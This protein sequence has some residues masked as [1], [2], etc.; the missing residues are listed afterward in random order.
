MTGDHG[1]DDPSAPGGWT[2]LVL[3]TWRELP[4]AIRSVADQLISMT[5]RSAPATDE[6][7]ARLDAIESQLDEHLGH[8]EILGRRELDAIRATTAA[9]ERRVAALEAHLR[10]DAAPDDDASRVPR[11]P[12]ASPD[13]F[14]Q[15]LARAG[16]VAVQRGLTTGTVAATVAGDR[17][18][19]IHAEASAPAER[20]RK[21]PRRRG[22]RA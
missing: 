15:V 6:V 10:D 1:S 17:N 12:M 4:A 9:L 22:R 18:P 7:A 11:L 13:A 16:E 20:S 8:A 19:E 3:R 14:R 21:T 2:D 5:G